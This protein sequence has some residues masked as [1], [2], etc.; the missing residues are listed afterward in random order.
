MSVKAK[1]G[2]EDIAPYTPGKSIES[3]KSEYNLDNIVKMASNENPFGC[4]VTPQQLTETFKNA[5]YY[6]DY[7]EPPNPP[8]SLILHH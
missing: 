7:N 3:V 6:P 4:P 8:N 5:H 2:I 1:P